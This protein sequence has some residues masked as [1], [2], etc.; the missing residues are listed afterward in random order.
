[1]IHAGYGPAQLGNLD[2]ANPVYLTGDI[3]TI[4]LTLPGFATVPPQG[5]TGLPGTDDV[6]AF[7]AAGLTAKV[8][9]IPG[10]TSWSG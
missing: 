7:C 2:F 5:T 10:G 1:V 8:Q 6:F 3:D 9:V 4:D